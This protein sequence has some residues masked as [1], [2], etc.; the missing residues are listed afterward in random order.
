MQSGR[1][2]GQ[3]EAVQRSPCCLPA[4]TV[5]AVTA[6]V[7]ATIGTAA[8]WNR[9]MVRRANVPAWLRSLLQVVRLARAN[10]ATSHATPLRPHMVKVN[11]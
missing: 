1:Y 6:S 7:V 11:L 2:G 9:P 10:A 5:R 3:V 4:M 8:Q